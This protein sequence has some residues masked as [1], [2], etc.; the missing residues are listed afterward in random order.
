MV[1]VYPPDFLLQDCVGRPEDNR[2]QTVLTT[3]KNIN[4]N[5]NSRMKM[6]RDWKKERQK[7]EQEN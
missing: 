5:C 6:L 3:Q 7:E 2:I 4:D 1:Y